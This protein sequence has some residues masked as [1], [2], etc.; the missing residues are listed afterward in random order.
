MAAASA[1]PLREAVAALAVAD[2]SR[3]GYQ[4]DK[5]RHWT[6]A[7]RDG[8]STRAEVLIDEAAVAP[9]VGPKCALAGGLWYSSYDDEYV[10]DARGV[11]IDHM[12]PLAE[13]WDSG[14]SAWTATRREAY[15]NDL[16]SPP[17]LIAVT[18]RSNRSK[19]DQDPSTWLPPYAAAQCGYITDW[20]SVKTRWGLTVDN[21]EKAVLV[22]KAAH[23]SNVPIVVGIA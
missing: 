13:A 22:E 2:E 21:N 8:C 20:V 9:E 4:R 5:F 15:A 6:D 3:D 7:D 12:V 14:A 16:D 11:D 1:V 23:C 10:S 19:A 18:A 17:A